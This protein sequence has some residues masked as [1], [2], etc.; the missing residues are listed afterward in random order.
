MSKLSRVT[1]S[2]IGRAAIGF[3]GTAI[4]LLGTPLLTP[5]ASAGTPV[6]VHLSNEVIIEGNVMQPS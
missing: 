5:D 6:A 2:M 1:Q 4:V 3:V